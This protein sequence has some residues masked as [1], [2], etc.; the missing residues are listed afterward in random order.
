MDLYCESV[1]ELQAAI[2]VI[3]EDRVYDSMRMAEQL[4]ED[5]R[6]NNAFL[7][8][9]GDGEEPGSRRAELLAKRT[10]E[11]VVHQDGVETF[12]QELDKEIA[13]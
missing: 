6:N 1:E 3:K 12:E 4:P 9:L 10:Q 11:V 8:V 5:G 13:R 2:T 7:P